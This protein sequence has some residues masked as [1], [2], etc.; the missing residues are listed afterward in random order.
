MTYRADLHCHSTCSDGTCTPIELLDLAKEVGLSGL[1]ITD[2]DTLDAY[3]DETLSHAKKMGIDLFTG[4]EFSTRYHKVSVHIL[5]Y[6]VQKTKALL[7][8]CNEHKRR[9]ENRNSAILEKLKSLSLPVSE[10]ELKAVQTGS[11][12]GRPHIA[13]VMVQKNYVSSIQEAFDRY[14]GD[15]KCCFFEGEPFSVQDAID[16]IHQAKGK[17]FIAHPHLIERRGILRIILGMNFDGIECYYSL[18][19]AKKVEKWLKI[20]KD[21]DWLISGGSDFH[22]AIKPHIKLGCSYV[23]HETVERIFS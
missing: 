9:R 21:K 13:Q 11:I 10:E 12:A 23:D 14:I 5:G 3:T 16:E 8:F 22:G 19:Y 17:A 18:L 1:S 15:G 2:H 20:A 6:G 4:V 7:A